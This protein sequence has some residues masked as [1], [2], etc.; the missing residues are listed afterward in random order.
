MLAAGTAVL[1]LIP[2]HDPD[3]TK[4]ERRDGPV[5]GAE[6]TADGGAVDAFDGA[7]VLEVGGGAEFVSQVSPTSA[8]MVQGEAVLRIEAEGGDGGVQS[9]DGRSGRLAVGVRPLG[10]C[11]R[12]ARRAKARTPTRPAHLHSGRKFSA[13]PPDLSR[14]NECHEPPF[15]APPPMAALEARHRWNFQGGQLRK[16]RS[17]WA[18]RPRLGKTVASSVGPTPNHLAMVAAY[19]STLVVGM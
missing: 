16:P 18:K 8:L 12:D 1:I 2:L 14:W 5:V 17:G 7:P 3:E 6:C 15:S 9:R 10:R 13:T 19:S 11:A 4:E